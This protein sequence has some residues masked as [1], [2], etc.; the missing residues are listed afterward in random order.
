MTF[1][2]PARL[3]KMAEIGDLVG[4]RNGLAE[5]KAVGAIVAIEDLLLSIGIPQTLSDLGLAPDKLEWVAEEAFTAKRLVNNNPR[6][7]DLLAANS[8]VSAAYSGK[9]IELLP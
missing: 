5:A 4:V 9:R 3:A 2:L 7:L 1:N 6:K 8:I